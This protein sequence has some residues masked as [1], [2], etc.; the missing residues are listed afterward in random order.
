MKKLLSLSLIA[1][2]LVLSACGGGGSDEAGFVDA[3]IGTWKGC[4]YSVGD[5]YTTRTRVFAKG[6]ANSMNMAV[7]SDNRYTDNKCTNLTTTETISGSPNNVV[8]LNKVLSF[9]GRTGHEGTVTFTNG[10]VDPFYITLSGNELR[11]GGGLANGV[12]SG[13]ADP[14]TKQ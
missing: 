8:Q 4:V 14:Y 2:A 5:F 12:F 3:Y 11:L 7:R 9:S 1:S 6:S 10:V 13:W